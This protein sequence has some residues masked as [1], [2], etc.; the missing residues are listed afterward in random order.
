M[1]LSLDN[2]LAWL[3]CNLVSQNIEISLNGNQHLKIDY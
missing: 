1:A 2:L 3:A